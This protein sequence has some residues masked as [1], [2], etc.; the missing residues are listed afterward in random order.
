[1]NAPAPGTVGSWSGT[2][3]FLAQRGL[4]AGAFI[5]IGCAD[6]HHGLF[7]L[8]SGFLPAAQLV[9]IDAN[10]VYEP[11]LRRIQ[12]VVG[13]HY[14][15]SAVSDQAGTVEFHGSAHPYWASAVSADDDYW[16][17]IN[18]QRGEATVIGCQTLDVLLADMALVPPYIIKLD[19]QGLEAAALRGAAATLPNTAVVI[20]EMLIGEFNP[21][22]SLLAERGFDLFDITNLHRTQAGTLGWFDGVYLHRAFAGL[23]P[24][25]TWAA[26]HNAEVIRLQEERRR[27]VLA[28]IDE[29]LALVRRG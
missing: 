11:S 21:L 26:E 12:S 7:A 6:G 2:L 16:T 14:R 23:V 28:G 24:R 1:M 29:L 25:E 19:I 20:C 17:S 8:L 13:G 27:G 5:D 3:Q 15:I 22:H 10:P 9:N 18:G 4:R